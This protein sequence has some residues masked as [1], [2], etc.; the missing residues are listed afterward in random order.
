MH[1]V[2]I[3]HLMRITELVLVC[4]LLAFLCNFLQLLFSSTF[5]ILIIFNVV[6]KHMNIKLSNRIVRK[7]SMRFI[8]MRL[9]SNV[10]SSDDGV[11]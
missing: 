11:N 4:V 2:I 10:S 1:A 8:S 9:T 3:L 6:G 5:E 7:R